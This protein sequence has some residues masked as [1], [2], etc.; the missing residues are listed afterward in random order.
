MIAF[1]LVTYLDS[2]KRVFN[3]QLVQYLTRLLSFLLFE[4]FTKIRIGPVSFFVFS[5]NFFTRSLFVPTLNVLIFADFATLSNCIFLDFVGCPPVD[6]CEQN[7]QKLC[8]SSF[9]VYKHPIVIREPRFISKLPSPSK[10]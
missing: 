1:I 8:E 4:I 6:S 7:Y 2:I 9:W 5:K 3:F 10:M